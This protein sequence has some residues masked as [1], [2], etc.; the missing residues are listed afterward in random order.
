MSDAKIHTTLFMQFFCILA[1][2]IK[3][4]SSK[5][6][7]ILKNERNISEISGHELQSVCQ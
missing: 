2:T 4:F 5:L 7:N 6:Y 1:S 3:L